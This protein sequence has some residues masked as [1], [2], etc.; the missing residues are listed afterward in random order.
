MAVCLTSCGGES[1][2]R[3]LASLL[4]HFAVGREP[5][6]DFPLVDRRNLFGALGFNVDWEGARRVPVH[7]SGTYWLVPGTAHLCI[8]AVPGG[9]Q[10]VGVV[11][12]DKDQALHHGVM[13]TRLDQ[14]SESRLM[15]GVVPEGVRAA[16]VRTGDSVEGVKVHDG[17]FVRLDSVM[18]PPDVV[19]LR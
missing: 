1:Q 2:S 4:S 16:M 14:R 10:S 12:A 17:L 15:V 13:Y 19:I 8:V 9:S 3:Q 11:C 5:R 7:R 6:G 18:R